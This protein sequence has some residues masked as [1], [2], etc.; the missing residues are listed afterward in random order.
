MVLTKIKS[1]F[2][3]IYLTEKEFSKYQGVEFFDGVTDWFERI[4]AYG[5]QKGIEIRHYIISCGLKS[6]IEGCEI[7]KHFYNIFACDY[8]AITSKA[9]PAKV[10]SSQ[11]GILDF[12]SR[13]MPGGAVDGLEQDVSIW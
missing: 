2:G 10:S 12:W 8:G 5:D 7:A 1:V 4:N 11:I 6:M 3:Y 9:T 13:F